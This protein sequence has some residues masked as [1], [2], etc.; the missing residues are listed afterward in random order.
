M[1]GRIVFGWVSDKVTD[2]KSKSRLTA[3]F[4]NNCCLTVSGL[5][6]MAIPFCT[7][8]WSVL[9]NSTIFGL[10]ICK[11][12]QHTLICLIANWFVPKFIAAYIALTSIIIVELLGLDNLTN[13]FGKIILVRGIA[14]MLGPPLAG[15]FC[16]TSVICLLVCATQNHSH[17]IN[18]CINK[19]TFKVYV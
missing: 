17:L 3:L 4:I 8:Y 14:A 9:L 1:T 12:N 6:V 11:F 19:F 15:K 13:A 18:A 5:T 7:T 10:F 2:P 16:S